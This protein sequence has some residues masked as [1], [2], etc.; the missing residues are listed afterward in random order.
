[1]ESKAPWTLSPKRGLC[2]KRSCARAAPRPA[3]WDCW[4]SR[5][6]V[7]WVSL[8]VLIVALALTGRATA[9]SAPWTARSAT[10]EDIE[11][12]L[13]TFDPGDSV[14]EAFGHTA[15]LVRSRRHRVERLYNYGLFDFGPDMLPNF[16]RGRLTF[17]VGEENPRSAYPY[18]RMEGR[19][20]RSQRLNIAPQER[21][22]LARSLARAVLPENR[23]YLYD[24]YRDN[25]STR[26]ADAINR[27][28]N[29]QFKASL[30][31]PGRMTLRDHT[32]RHV[33]NMPLIEF[34]MMHA[35]GGSVDEPITRYEE[36]FLPIELERAV[37]QASVVSADGKRT[38]LVSKQKIL[39]RAERKPT[40][41]QPNPFWRRTLSVGLCVGALLLAFGWRHQEP[42]VPWRRMGLGLLLLILG[43][44]L[45]AL[46]T[47]TTVVS[48]ATDHQVAYDNQ[49]VLLSNPLLLGL[50]VAAVGALRNRAY[51]HRWLWAVALSVGGLT[52]TALLLK[53]QPWAVQDNAESLTLLV[54]P[55]VALAIVAWRD[56]RAQSSEIPMRPGHAP[57]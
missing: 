22:A 34:L 5:A 9:R 1:M 25:C 19:E 8:A 46:G 7:A 43:G 38:P 51:W 57:A 48:F 10:P 41:E 11:I 53:L 35:M 12:E 33:E 30:A 44:I 55:H 16:A 13:V 6:S 45:G 4:S 28:T 17:W 24:H 2:R 47:L 3:Q 20:I 50:C 23:E 39:F 29:G 49:N 42:L 40:P 37:G 32:R 15:L 56:W 52:A 54:P 21:L 26:L 27:A 31:G 18:Y 14:A 36:L